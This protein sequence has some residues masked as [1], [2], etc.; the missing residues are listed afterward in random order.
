LK[1]DPKPGVDT[2]GGSFVAGSI[3]TGG[4]TFVGRDQ[5]IINITTSLVDAAAA[6]DIEDQL[7]EPG[8]PPFQG[9]QYFSE[10]DADRFFGRE[11]LTSR[12]VA[13]L[14]RERFLA[15]VGASGSGKSSLLRAGV[16][17]S[18][19]RGQKL[20][21]GV[22]PPS[23]S[24]KWGMITL[25]PGARPMEALAASIA[26]PGEP[27]AAIAALRDELAEDASRFS[28]AVRRR[29]DHHAQ[30]HLLLFV[31]QFEEVF[32]LCRHAEER[33]AFIACLLEAAGQEGEIPLTVLMALR[34]DYYADVARHDRL[35][36]AVSQHQEF[37]G[38]MTR[39][40]LVRAIDRPLA[41]GNWRI[42]EGLIEVILDD[43]GYEPGALPL[44]SHALHETWIRRR[45]R[46]LTL[47]GYTESGGVRGAVAQS[48]ESVFENLRSEHQTVA[49]MIFLRMAEVGRDSHDTRRKATYPELI[50]RSTDEL[51]IDAVIDI[52]ADARLVTTGT[53]PPEGT[54]V[55]EVAHEALI[56]EWTRLRGWLEK[57]REGLILHQRLT[58]DATEWVRLERGPDVLY[59][60]A[61]LKLAQAWAEA[62]SEALC[63][64]DQE[65]LDASRVEAEAEAKRLARLAR[66]ARAQ[67]ALIGVAAVL[68]L[69]LGIL[70]YNAYRASRKPA[71]MT[72]FYNIA[73]ADFQLAS[74]APAAD[75]DQLVYDSLNAILGGNP[76][77]LVWHDSPELRDENV[78]IGSVSGNSPKE[79]SRSAQ[80]LAERLNADMLIYT[81]GD[82]DPAAGSLNLEFH[83][84]P[85]SDYNYED[86]Q[87]GFQLDCSIPIQNP[88]EIAILQEQLADCV[89]ALAWIALGLTEAN[90]GHSVEAVEAFL[91]ADRDYP[92]SETIKFLIGRE[93]LFLVDRETVLAFAQEEFESRA[94]AAFTA[95]LQLSPDYARAH[96]GLGSLYYKRARDLGAEAGLGSS[97]L[98][99]A[100]NLESLAE[101]LSEVERAVED[102]TAA[103]ELSGQEQ[104][105]GI[106]LESVA[107]LG[108]GNSYRL[109]GEIFQAQ[110]D[111]A[112]A[113]AQF[114]KA[115][116]TLKQTLGPLEAASQERYLTQAYEYL[117]TTYHLQ[118]NTYF[119]ELDFA[120]G[121]Q[122]ADLA[123]EY[124]DRCIAQAQSTQ[125]LIIKNDIVS[126][127]CLPNREIMQKYL[128]SLGGES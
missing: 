53:Q 65:F 26:V 66:A 121:Q 43:I 68:L 127:V 93:Y 78:T 64:L 25:T 55:V 42:Q 95:S 18:L 86:L 47:S 122:T 83:L 101:A 91:R 72:G 9:L 75:P 92:D 50:T 61:R 35:R 5:Y 29:L 2:G 24:P 28:L 48:A 1:D 96:I 38:A 32:T 111:H 124:Y 118:A 33:E 114:Q 45:G 12:L 69:A 90:L 37:I 102:Y 120:R 79:A 8:D 51:V 115:I 97:I 105:S 94:E 110:N 59:R 107:R 46:T 125:D 117:G 11:L 34:A 17:P 82:P 112:A 76:N 108:L 77:I 3:D 109:K 13:R 88:S 19:R 44:L 7:P 74:G 123:L 36:Q 15:V 6:L 23:D 70:G 116:E 67:R 21:E 87:G 4:G 16:I 52:L 100:P 39:E 126:G 22:M 54:K 80:E 20:A 81:A 98:G 103:L 27:L 85:R 10:A 119:A 99:E 62:N 57:D 73:V 56:R 41:Q 104:P 106:P 49:R 71:E 14:H 40:E 31:D 84:S 60:G 63:L 30:P 128:D 89:D 58:E 113:T